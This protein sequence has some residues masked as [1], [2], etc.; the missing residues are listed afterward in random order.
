[1]LT[2]GVLGILPLFPGPQARPDPDDALLDML[3][4]GT[5]MSIEPQAYTGEVKAEVEAYL[6]R[7]N[8]FRSARPMPSSG[9]LKI[10]HEA[11]VH[12]ERRL[13]AVADDPDAPRLAAAYVDA[14]RPCYEWEGSHDC[15]EREALFADE[16][17]AAHPEGSF[18]AYL[19]LLSAHRWLCAAE[20]YA[21][22]NLSA[23]AARSRQRSRERLAVARRSERLLVRTAA[24]RLAVR[25]R[26][27][28]TAVR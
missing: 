18:R 20:A 13:V 10:V 5:Y 17:H 9:E 3:V 2:A 8:D 28:S 1:M 4:W 21:Y 25:G 27:L 26:C 22:E 7:A 12:Y 14:L 16:Y 11:Q 24:A 19:P 15:P 23:D 6:R